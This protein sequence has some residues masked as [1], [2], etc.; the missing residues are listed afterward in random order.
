MLRLTFP[1]PINIWFPLSR[2]NFKT[3]NWIFANNA[4]DKFTPVF[5][6]DVGYLKNRI[7]IQFVGD[8]GSLQYVVPVTETE[9][10]VL[11][12]YFIDCCIQ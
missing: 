6:K 12:Y 1:T 7:E 9:L 5:C 8:G 3:L 2:I 4:Q 11:L 10:R